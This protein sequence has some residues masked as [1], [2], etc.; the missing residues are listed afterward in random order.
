MTVLMDF[1]SHHMSH[2]GT[3]VVGEA[4][5]GSTV[6]YNIP[7]NKFYYYENCTF[8]RGYCMADAGWIVGCQL[9]DSDT[10]SN[11]GVIMKDGEI[12]IPSVF[13]SYSSSN[14]HSVTPDGSRVCGVVGN[15]GRGMSNLPFYCDL[16]ASGN[17]GKIQLLPTPEKDFFGNRPQYCTATWIS[18]DGKTIAGQVIDNRGFFIYPILYKE[19]AQGTWEYSLP[20]ESLFNMDKLDLPQPVGDFDDEYPNLVYPE[21]THFMDPSQ[22]NAW[23]EAYNYWQS[24]NFEDEYDPYTHL[25]NFMTDQEM[26]AY[27]S[28]VYAYNEAVE[29]YNYKNEYYWEQVYK[30]VACSV[31]FERNAMAMSPDGK[32][33]AS[34]RYYEDPE[35]DLYDNV[36]V[37]Y[38]PYQ[39]NLVTGEI[40]QL[41]DEVANLNVNQVFNNGD[42]LCVTPVASVLPPRSWLYQ[43]EKGSLISIQDYVTQVNPV[44]G[45]WYE[46]NLSAYIP[47]GINEDGTY[48][49]EYATITGIVSASEDMQIM[50]GGVIGDAIEGLGM[51]I[52]YLF[53]DMG[54]AGVEKIT[55]EPTE[56]GVYE[57]F[58][59]QGVRVLTTKDAALL[60]SLDKGL[61]I[62]NGKK[63]M[64][65]K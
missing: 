38:V 63:V 6:Y 29:E 64:I 59:L 60:N 61:Y 3:Q 23:N 55:L 15:S 52:S 44:Y 2:D 1:Y 37:T 25:E 12:I 48:K 16:D 26:D 28:A 57:V 51:D 65:R 31:F 49:Y 17:F 46:E 43:N 4:S 11:T 9:F 10:Q 7:Q 19:N 54:S 24:H 20:S 30:I 21:P 47:V 62:I 39:F 50:C 8:G 42:V 14:I 27:V 56:S 18:D 58:N 53:T 22:I 35:A 13:N 34:S 36:P 33:L 40:L 5:D 32:W 45:A 41:A